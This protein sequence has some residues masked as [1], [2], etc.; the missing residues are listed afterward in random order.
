MD[1]RP[2]SADK[3]GCE[4][5]GRWFRL[6]QQPCF[7]HPTAFCTRKRKS[8]IGISTTPVKWLAQPQDALKEPSGEKP[9]IH[10]AMH[11]YIQTRP[12]SARPRNTY[13]GGGVRAVFSASFCDPGF[14]KVSFW[15]SKPRPGCRS[16]PRTR[17]ARRTT[18]TKG[19]C[20]AMREV[21]F[22]ATIPLEHERNALVQVAYIRRG[23]AN[24]AAAAR[25]A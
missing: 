14:V 25:A 16:S 11:E 9:A 21:K 8:Q 1:S 12:I 22:D 20:Q 5:S 23:P 10:H 3:L 4:A 2:G 19:M 24:F 6:S 13:N 17:P 7:T 18:L 15:G